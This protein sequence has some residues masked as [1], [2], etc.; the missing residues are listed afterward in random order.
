M[1]LYATPSK[2]PSCD[3]GFHTSLIPV[4]Q[5]YALTDTGS[6]FSAKSHHRTL[7][8][9]LTVDLRPITGI[10]NYRWADRQ[11][12]LQ[13]SCGSSAS[14]QNDFAEKRCLDPGNPQPPGGGLVSRYRATMTETFFSAKTGRTPHMSE[15]CSY[16]CSPGPMR[17]DLT[18]KASTNSDH[19]FLREKAV[20][21][22]G[23]S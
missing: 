20:P 9:V 22:T 15:P 5:N 21:K 17:R 4:P 7:S 13:A 8:V 10:L 16:N 3:H 1:S 19:V 14:P 6:V 11:Y 2:S 12:V 23:A 18:N